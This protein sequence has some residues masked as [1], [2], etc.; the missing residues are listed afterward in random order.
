LPAFNS[1]FVSGVCIERERESAMQ[2]IIFFFMF[3]EISNY[4]EEKERSQ[5]AKPHLF[6]LYPRTKRNEMNSWFYSIFESIKS[7]KRKEYRLILFFCSNSYLY[8]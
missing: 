7:I 2:R 6:I 3:L 5:N 1:I 4:I 8:K